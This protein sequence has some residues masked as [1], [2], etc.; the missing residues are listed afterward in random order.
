MRPA[1][2]LRRLCLASL[3]CL[4][5][6]AHAQADP[7][8][9][10]S[11]F[12]GAKVLCVAANDFGYVMAQPGPAFAQS[13]ALDFDPM[14]RAECPA[15]PKLVHVAS[16]TPVAQVDA[17]DVRESSPLRYVVKPYNFTQTM[18]TANSRRE[19]PDPDDELA[20]R[21]RI[22]EETR[23]LF[24][25][26]GEENIDRLE[27]TL[28][29]YRDNKEL[30]L[31][32]VWKL[33][34]AYSFL[35][36]LKMDWTAED[37]PGQRP[38]TLILLEEWRIKY[39]SSPSPYIFEASISYFRTT[40]ILR[41]RLARSTYP[42]GIDALKTKLAEVRTFLEKNKALAAQ[43]PHYYALM[44]DI[45]RDQRVS[46]DEMLQVALEGASRFPTY[47]EIYYHATRAFG[48]LSRKPYDDLEA[49]AN[50]AVE[51]TKP[52]LGDEMYA[53]I[54]W[55]ATQS[56]VDI[57]EIGTLKWNWERMKSSMNTITTRYPVQWNIQNFAMLSCLVN[58]SAA[59]KK[60]MNMA[61]GIPLAR[62]WSQR[63]FFDACRTLAEAPVQTG[64]PETRKASAP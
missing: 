22:G 11:A 55:A 29:R 53:R 36:R 28:A 41:D 42:G 63:E 8:K 3:A 17:A 59:T 26:S 27:A 64:H 44:I 32:G 13:V 12:I 40:A 54:Y 6:S 51:K 21:S 62:V 43:D 45:L 58:D 50:A 2:V 61:K 30:T 14:S 35:P 18:D 60:F 20:E 4:S 52:A 37:Q 34:C 9:S 39:P 16:E 38:A 10:H 15:R 25:G 24:I 7:R 1:Q 33:T 56:I 23:W 5:V 31:S 47:S 57:N 19:T 49:L 48:V 46:T